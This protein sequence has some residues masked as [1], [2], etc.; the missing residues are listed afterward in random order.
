MGRNP[1]DP[2]RGAALVLGSLVVLTS[3]CADGSPSASP[4]PSSSDAVAEW[5]GPVRTGPAGPATMEPDES[6]V[7]SAS[8]PLD[9]EEPYVDI[10][11]IVVDVP[12]QP[13][14]TLRLA[15]APPEASTLDPHHTVISYGLVFETTGDEV[16]D[17][18]VGISNE[19]SPA[20][21]YRTW[22]T[23]LNSG[24]TIENETMNYGYPV[25]FAH[26]DEA[27]PAEPGARD[28]MFTFLSN[29]PSSVTMGTRFYAWASVEED[30]AVVAWDYAPDGGW[31]GTLPE[32]AA[33]P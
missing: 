4:M 12:S 9:A 17:F 21:L 1:R 24:V 16:P 23:Y 33:T 13:H 26:P 20:G 25:E 18:L 7:G 14:W 27:L 5:T 32:E 19:G 2:M 6:G 11:E 10:Q 29:R 31:I 22:I 30:G 28:M 15:A 8:D 3:A